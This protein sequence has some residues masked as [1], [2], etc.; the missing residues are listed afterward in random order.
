MP[1]ATDKRYPGVIIY[2][3]EVPGCL[4]EPTYGFGGSI[5]EAIDKK[6]PSLGGRWYCT[7]HRPADGKASLTPE[8]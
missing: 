7:T 3:C 8:K 6:N 4:E 2:R 5:R 1:L